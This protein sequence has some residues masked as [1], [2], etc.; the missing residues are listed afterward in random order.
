[1]KQLDRLKPF[2]CF[3]TLLLVCVNCFSQQIHYQDLLGYWSG[4]VEDT[5]GKSHTL[6]VT[7]R[8]TSIQGYIAKG[9][10]IDDDGNKVTTFSMSSRDIRHWGDYITADFAGGT[11]KSPRYP[12][13]V[14]NH[15]YVALT[16]PGTMRVLSF[17]YCGVFTCNFVTASGEMMK[18]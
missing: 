13:N 2:V 11:Y 8:P 1:M 10:F 6:S 14:K 17:N 3:F 9:F 5:L 18:N 7:I 4:H 12:D 15:L 16:S